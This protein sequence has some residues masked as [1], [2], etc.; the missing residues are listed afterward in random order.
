MVDS[1]CPTCNTPC[2]GKY[3]PEC[4]ER[5][6]RNSQR[7]LLQFLKDA[8]ASILEITDSRIVRSFWNLFRRPGT[9]TVAYMEGRRVPYLHPFRLF[10]VANVVFFL[11]VSLTGSSPVTTKL[12][13]HLESENF[14]HQQLAKRL[15]EQHLAETD[16][17]FEAY[18]ADFDR[19]IDIY[20]K[21][22]VF[23]MIPMMAFVLGILF[24][25]RREYAVKHLVFSCHAYTFLLLYN[26]LLITFPTAII[27]GLAGVRNLLDPVQ[28]EF[29]YS[30]VSL[31][32]Q[33]GFFYFGLRKAYPMKV[34]TSLVLGFFLGLMIYMIL[35]IY[36]SV[37]FFVTYYAMLMW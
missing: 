3:C 27:V 34:W 15:V 26:F 14:F 23:I 12:Y 19:R 24:L 18:E 16:Q 29:L 22:L 30:S 9:L 8:I 7:S 5:L 25:P 2:E 35:L 37:Q 20:S 21:T 11:A 31:L 28:R 33:S 17:T 1:V 10:I 6:D 4:G 13:T 32:A 36:R